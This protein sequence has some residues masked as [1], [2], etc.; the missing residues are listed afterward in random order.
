MCVYTDARPGDGE[1]IELRSSL[2]VR[3]R[4]AAVRWVKKDVDN[5]Y[6]IGLMFV[7]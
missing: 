5:L 6:K 4:R 2:P 1:Q 3:S 7:D